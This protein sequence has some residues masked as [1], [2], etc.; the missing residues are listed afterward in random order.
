MHRILFS[1]LL[2]AAA[3]LNACGSAAPT[4]DRSAAKPPPRGGCVL[5]PDTTLTG[6]SCIVRCV[7][8]ST[9]E[10][11][12][13]SWSWGASNGSIIAREHDNRTVWIEFLKPGTSRLEVTGFD[14]DGVARCSADEKIDR[15]KQA[16]A[17]PL[18]LVS[19]QGRLIDATDPPIQ[20]GVRQPVSLDGSQCYD[21]EGY[22]ADSSSRGLSSFDWSLSYLDADSDGDGVPEEVE[23]A[24][25][26]GDVGSE[27]SVYVWGKLCIPDRDGNC[28]VDLDG[29]GIPDLVLRHNFD[30]LVLDLTPLRSPPADGGDVYVW[31]LS[32]TESSSSGKQAHHKGHVTVL[33]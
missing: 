23:V 8:E 20:G 9:S 2:F 11:E 3:G 24:T 5:R 28:H 33:K 16:D 27:A 13:L 4:A 29:D 19:H 12:I 26:T 6:P 31:K 15:R 21:P 14:A 30:P 18:C 17:S 25:K 7:A 32:V 22:A 1:L 10:I